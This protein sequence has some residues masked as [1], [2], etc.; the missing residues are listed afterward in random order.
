MSDIAP[1]FLEKIEEL[2]RS[3]ISRSKEL[4]E[5]VRLIAAGEVKYED[6]YRAAREIGRILS[7]SYGTAI[8]TGNLPDE[9]MYY[10]IAQRVIEPTMEQAYS[11]IADVVENTQ[12]V[13]NQKS[14]IGIKAIRPELKKDRIDGIINR[15]S[16]AEKFED[17]AWILG[18]PIITFCQSV[19]DDSVK[20]NVE[21][22][23]RAGLEPKIVR[24]TAGSCCE[25]C[26]RLAGIYS[27]PDVPHDVYRRHENCNCTVEFDPGIGKK[28][29]DVWSKKWRYEKDFDR[30][31]ERRS[32]ENKSKKKMLSES[33][34][35]VTSEYIRYAKPRTGKIIYEEGVRDDDKE[36]SKW[37]HEK[38]GGDIRVLKDINRQHI[39]TPDACWDGKYWEYKNPKTK[40]AIDKRLKAAAAQLG[41][42][43]GGIVIDVTG[44]EL[45]REDSINTIINRLPRRMKKSVDVIV[46]EEDN[47]IMV[48]RYK[49][50][51]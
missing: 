39:K 47:L 50:E 40:N 13:L 22:Q 30:I 45:S 4:A 33:V 26:S 21:F 28:H 37:L 5:I 46:K 23:G 15:L 38:L 34:E 20:E 14:G 18:A 51:E 7:S 31:R 29:Q 6:A 24:K 2:Y 12:N 35:D 32:I 44:S 10:N 25:W 19:V 48:M 16:N 1:G 41:D 11:D 17:V 42:N 36:V 43:E 49:K 27:Y 9:K 8:D 3:Q